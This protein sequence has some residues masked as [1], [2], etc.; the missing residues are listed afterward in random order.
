MQWQKSFKTDDRVPRSEGQKTLA[1][2]AFMLTSQPT[3]LARKAMVMEMWESGAHTIVCS[4]LILTAFFFI[5]FFFPSQVLI[6]HNTPAGFGAIAEAREFLLSMGRKEFEDPEAEAWP[7]RGAHV[8]APVSVHNY[9]DTVSC[10]FGTSFRSALMIAPAPYMALDSVV[11]PA[12]SHSAF[13]GPRFCALQNTL[14]LDT[15]ILNI[16]TS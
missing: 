16:R 15:R 5:C 10:S 14:V 8:V 2:S 4:C 9:V 12:A 3:P 13:N 6:D 7:V 11:F 1:L